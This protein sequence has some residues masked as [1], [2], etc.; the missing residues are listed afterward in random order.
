ME[1]LDPAILGLHHAGG[2]LLR[3]EVARGRYPED[4]DHWGGCNVIYWLLLAL[5]NL[6]FTQ[7]PGVIN[8]SALSYIGKVWLESFR[9][10]ENQKF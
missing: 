7:K 10:E 4:G 5:S 1:S 9:L 8:L 6:K 3:H 2:D